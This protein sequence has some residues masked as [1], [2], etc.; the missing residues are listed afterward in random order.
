MRRRGKPGDDDVPTLP[1]RD[2]DVPALPARE[3]EAPA[4]SPGAT[5]TTGPETTTFDDSR[6]GLCHAVA[7]RV[8]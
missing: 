3:G 5:A 8:Q 6:P 2:D 4:S 1:P 7:G